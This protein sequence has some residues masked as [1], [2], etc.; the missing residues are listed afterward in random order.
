MSELLLTNARVVTCDA[1][2]G[3]G[4]LGVIDRGAV[5]IRDGVV[6]AVGGAG[7]VRLGDD[8]DGRV[9]DVDGRVVM[10][11]FVDCHTHAC[12]AG[13]RVEEWELKRKGLSYLEIL[14]RGGGIM[15]SVRAVREASEEEL[16]QGLLERLNLMLA[17]GTTTVEV[18]S[19]YG[20][21]TETE[22][23]MLRAIV[24]AGKRFAGTVVPTALLGHALDPDVEREAFVARTVD[25]TLPAVS[26]AFSGIAVDAYCED[27]AW[28]VAE[29][30]RLFSKAQA[31][32]HPVRVHADQ[33]NSLGMVEAAIENGFVSVDHLES[34]LPHLLKR[35]GG[36]KTTGVM[37]PCC[38]FHV[39][40]RYGNG[41][42]LI[43]A[44]GTLAIATNWNPGSAPC[45]NMAMAIA[46]AVRHLGLTAGE[47]IVAATRAGAGVLGLQAGVI[48]EGGR[49][50]LVVLAERDER[51][52]GHSFGMNAVAGVICGGQIVREPALG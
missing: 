30:E 29:C 50:D 51:E 39:D 20:L 38:G 26:E 42:E 21:D 37:L 48:R 18:K 47:A 11:G 45:G 41:R 2:D 28:S 14:K 24:R 3:P 5:L 12:W 32:G 4:G 8:A 44:G 40:G 9:V 6:A 35:L 17:H 13:S 7:V 25:E 43:D 31:L 27:G 52:L 23:K 49:A 22:L 1:D 34:T 10:P 46:L 33:F 36:S 16:A 15:S 19:G